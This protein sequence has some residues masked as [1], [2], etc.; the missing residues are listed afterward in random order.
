MP[1][2]LPPTSRAFADA[3]HHYRQ[4]RNLTREELAYVLD[5]LGYGLTTEEL[6][7]IEDA[8]RHAT[9]DDLIAIAAALAV[10]PSILLSHIPADSLV[11]DGSLGTGL[12]ADVEQSE[13]RAW[14]EGRTTLGYCARLRCAAEQ[15]SRLQIRTSHIEDQLR[16]AVEELRELGELA[17]QEADAPQVIDLHDRI[18]EGE[19]NLIREERSLS[20]AE[21]LIKKLGS[22][23]SRAE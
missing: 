17:S 3:V 4:L 19:Y 14:I 20:M 1:H 13:L 23:A 8:E 6:R 2:D 18:R 21:E 7:R 12:P 10:S 16:A 15:V 9:V 5:K 11:P 22:G